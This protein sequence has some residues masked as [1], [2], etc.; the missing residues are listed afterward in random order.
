MAW[1]AICA[2][3]AI[4][5]YLLF[6]PPVIGVA[7]N[8]DFNRVMG[9]AGIAY[10]DPHESYA[11]RYFGY[12]HQ[13]YHY[14][15]FTS[16]GYVS[17]HVLLVAIA[18]GIGRLIDS[19]TF[20]IRVLGFCYMALTLSAL[21]LLVRYAP[22]IRGK[23]ATGIA[24]SFMAVIGIGIFCDVGYTAYYQSFFGEPFALVAT[25]LALGA[26]VAIASRVDPD[27]RSSTEQSDPQQIS[28]PPSAWLLALF[29]SAGVALASSKIQNAPIGFL[30]AILAWRMAALRPDRGWRLRARIG[31]A[32][33]ALS[34]VLMMALAPDQLRHINLY[35]SIFFGALKDTPDLKRDMGELGIPDKYAGLAGTNYF[36][37]DTIVPQSDPTLRREVLDRLSHRD[38]ALYYL[39]HPERFVSKLEKAAN[40]G[41]AVRPYY[42][43]NY[44]E[45]A[46]RERSK[47]SYA[48]SAW[49]EWKHRDM[50]NT[51]SWFVSCYAVYYALLAAWWIR[52]AG[53]PGTRLLS[54][55]LAVIG[56]A[57][58]V[59][60]TVS[61]M[62]DGEADLGKHLFMF[63]VCFDIMAASAL[64]GGV[65]GLL[66]GVRALTVR[67]GNRRQ[68]TII[69][70]PAKLSGYN[71]EE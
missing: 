8:G 20:D 40:N 39:R 62:G 54:E 19:H 16:G 66:W 69:V 55:L 7:D 3:A 52:S 10:A 9:A 36:Q 63:N 68:S 27:K 23:Y 22:A 34:A 15:G 12:A 49:S 26:A 44:S 13:L 48:F 24:A 2:A 42:L 70:Q 1:I 6:V 32:I 57:G 50:P 31:A 37:K 14:G 5:V 71:R 45:S 56:A 67:S 4:I 43:G 53:R 11:D 35:Q 65:Y 58:A 18:G 61:L 33:L 41:T 21:W 29:V 25:L 64:V 60:V 28:R 59:A 17:T 46:G 51:L 47:L 30:L 38:I